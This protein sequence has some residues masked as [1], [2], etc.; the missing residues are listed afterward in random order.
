MVSRFSYWSG[1]E[2][3]V[4]GRIPWVYAALI[5]VGYVVVWL[6]PASLFVLFGTYAASAPFVWMW[7]KAFRKK[8]QVESG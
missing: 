3:N 8:R 2:L 5:P 1:K 7:R 4:R 6:A